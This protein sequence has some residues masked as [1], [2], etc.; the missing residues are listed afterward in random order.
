MRLAKLLIVIAGFILTGCGGNKIP[1]GEI[2]YAITYP[3]EEISGIMAAIL[4]ETMTIIFKDTKVMTVIEKGTIFSTTIITDESD[5][6]I[7]MRLNFGDKKYFVHLTEQEQ[8]DLRKSQPT[9]K[10]K[11][12]GE[13]DSISGMWATKYSVE[14]PG[15]EIQPTDAWFTEDVVPSDAYWFSSYED[16]KGLP[17]IYD[18]ERYGIIMHLEAVKFTEREVKEEEFTKP[19]EINEEVTLKQYEDEVQELFDI[20]MGD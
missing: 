10:V 16:I 18:V 8:A 13:Q 1:E 7:E 14:Y 17:V 19:K 12:T 3:H 6:S 20:L 15:G 9:Y 11:A 4:P 5:K 2:E